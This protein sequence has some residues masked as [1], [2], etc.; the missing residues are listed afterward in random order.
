MVM[1]I[2]KKLLPLGPWSKCEALRLGVYLILLSFIWIS[3]LYPKIFVLSPEGNAKA[4]L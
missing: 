3:L 1:K 4:V 2:F